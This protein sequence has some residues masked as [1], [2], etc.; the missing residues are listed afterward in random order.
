MG[1]TT[2]I[3]CSCWAGWL[4]SLPED[5][6]LD[7]M[8]RQWREDDA[9]GVTDRAFQDK[10]CLLPGGHAGPHEWTPNDQFSVRFL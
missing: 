6:R 4:D 2:G 5:E 1:A 3:K 9:A 10:T 8:A 7:E